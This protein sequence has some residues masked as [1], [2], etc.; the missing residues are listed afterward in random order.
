MARSNS[1]EGALVTLVKRLRQK[2][3][4]HGA[5]DPIQT[6]HGK[7][8]KLSSTIFHRNENLLDQPLGR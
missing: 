3:Y 7:G 1:S 6:V 8:L 5:E 4:K 2:M